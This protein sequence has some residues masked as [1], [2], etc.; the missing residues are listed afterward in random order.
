MRVRVAVL[1][2]GYLGSFHLQ[3]LLV[4]PRVQIVA[5]IDTAPVARA[6]A[7][8]TFGIE[9]A[10]ALSDVEALDAVIIAA[11]TSE[12][13]RLTREALERDLHVLVEKPFTATLAQAQQLVELAAKHGRIL[14]VGHVERFN[15]AI[16]A[17][18][19]VFLP[20]DKPRYVVSERLAPF[21]G[22]S[23]D[24][25]VVRDLMIHDLDLV[26][27]WMTSPLVEVRAVGVPVFTSAVDMTSA[28]L[29][30]ADG[31]VAQLS[32]GRASF[33][34]IRKLR[35]FTLERYISIDCAQHEVKVVRRAPPNDL[36]EWPQLNAEVV[37][38][39]KYDALA[40]QDRAFIDCIIQNNTPRVSAQAGLS[41][42]QLA[43]AVIEAM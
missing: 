7:T 33:D 6:R 14:Q 28:R 10:T 26:A 13:F 41:A 11:P 42:M 17:A 23:A 18:E 32:A 37:T 16:C 39:D 38:V 9:V 31:T 40:E 1:G 35:L 4:D 21:S 15:P 24:I 20:H 19:K 22:R 8:Q 2:A 12:H 34:P 36:S 3:K 43:Q 30:F 5:A 27:S 29:M 25:D